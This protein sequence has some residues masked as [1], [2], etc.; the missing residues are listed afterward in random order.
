LIADF[1]DPLPGRAIA[2]MLGLAPGDRAKFKSW[3]DDIYGF[4]GFSA[5]PVSSRARRGTGSARELKAYLTE[6][7]ADRRARPR[8]DLLS[9]M[10]LAEEQGEKLTETE[11]FSNVVGMLNASHET[12]TNLI[13]NTVL[14][15]LRNPEQWQRLRGDLTLVSNAVE[16]GLR[17]ESPVQM[18]LR[19][20][21]E[22]VKFSEVTVPGG[23]R[24]VVVLGAANRDPMFYDEPDRFDLARGGVKHVAFGGGP[25]FCLGAALGRLEG[26]LAI[27]AIC[28]R[29]PNLRLAADRFAWRPLP[30]FRGL[31]ALPVEV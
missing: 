14:A 21:A 17:Y 4:M 9:A 13:A 27:E 22:D 2:A 7:F 28:Q 23:D 25:H 18:V 24:A 8:D 31:V 11:L 26:V 3:T 5:E 19:R 29:L 15:L 1:A 16:E 6:L 20:A 10:V 30:L 12:T